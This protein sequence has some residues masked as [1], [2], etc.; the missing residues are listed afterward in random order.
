MGR[1]KT[2]MPWVA[3]LLILCMVVTLMPFWPSQ[4]V[5]A[6][7]DCNGNDHEVRFGAGTRI[8]NLSCSADNA[9]Q[10]FYN[11]MTPGFV[12]TETDKD[13]R[14]DW[15]N[16][17][18]NTGVDDNEASVQFDIRIANN[19]DLAKLAQSGHAKVRLGWN[20]LVSYAGHILGIETWTRITSM[21]V[22]VDGVKV[23]SDRADHGDDTGSRAATVDIGPNSVI[24]IELYGEGDDDDGDLTG[25]RGFYIKFEDKERPVLD[26]YTFIGNG[27]E[28]FNTT[29]QQNELY[30]K[31]S[32]YL[33]LT[34]NFSEPV[35]PTAV[36]PQNSDN[37]LKQPIFINPDGTGLPAAGEQQY[38]LN[39]TYTAGNLDT[40]HNG[41]TFQ[42]TGSKYHSSG[43]LPLDPKKIDGQSPSGTDD[44]NKSILEKM[45]GA[46]FTD[47]AGNIATITS[48]NFITPNNASNNYL[49]GKTVNPFDY[50]NGGYR[51]IVDAV[52]PK[53]TKVGNGI[54]PEILTGVTLNKNDGFDFTVQ[55]TEPAIVKRGWA[56]ADTYLLLN[57][58]MKAKYVSGSGTSTW[59]FHLDIQGTL[60]EEAPLLKVIA[61]THEMANGADSN[62]LQDYAGNMLVQP[63]NYDSN[64]DGLFVPPD[65]RLLDPKFWE[66]SN[67]NSKIDWAQLSIDNTPPTFSYRYEF[68]SATNAV[69]MKN[70]KITIDA[71]DAPLYVPSKDPVGAGTTRPSKGIYR[72][73]NMTGASSPAVGLVY[74]MWSQDKTD[75]FVKRGLDPIPAVKRYSLSAKQPREDLYPEL[76]AKYDFKIANNKTNLIALPPEALTDENSGEWY[77]HTWTA[78]MTWDTAR[79]LMQ[80]EKKKNYVLNNPAQ[81]QAWKDEASGSDADKTFYADSKALAEVGKYGDLNTWPLADFQKDDSNWTHDVGT[82]KIDNRAPKVTIG[83]ALNDNSATVQ[84]PLTIVDE[85]SG[86]KTSQYQWVKETGGVGDPSDAGWI[87]ATLTG[88]SAT[89]STLN[90]VV[91]DGTYRLYVKTSDNAGNER[92]E[93]HTKLITV[94]STNTISGSFEP[95]ANP[96][97][98]KSH[99]ITFKISGLPAAPALR[100]VTT[101][102]YSTHGVVQSVMPLMTV[103]S[104][105][106][107]GY[108]FSDSLVRPDA[109]SFVGLGTYDDNNGVRT[110]TVPADPTKNGEQYIHIMVKVS[111]SGIDKFYYYSKLYYFDNLPPDVKF[112]KSGSEY[113]LESVN[114]TVTVDEKY[115]KAGVTQRYMLLDDTKPAPDENTAGWTELPA[116][117]AVSIDNKALSLNPGDTASYRV[118]VLVKDCAGNSAVIKSGAFKIMKPEASDKPPVDVK[119]DLLYLYGDAEDGYTAI[120]KLGLVADAGDKGA[121]DFSVSPDNGASWVKWRPYTNFVAL[122][123]PT[124]NAADLHIQVKYRTPSGVVGEPRNLDIANVAKNEPVYALATLNNPKPVN[125]STGAEIEITAPLGLKVVPSAVNPSEPTRSGN[126]FTVR[127]N[128]LYAF[129]LT[130]PAD[131]TRKDTLYIVIKNVDGTPPEGTIEYLT[132]GAT[133]GNVTVKLTDLSE[134][135][136]VINNNGRLTHTFEENGQFIFNIMDEAGNA[137]TVTANVY[138]IDKTPPNVKVVRSYAYGENN[139]Q[140]YGTIR[141]G[142]GNVIFSAGVSLVLQ[143]VNPTDKDFIVLDG[144]KTITLEQNGIASFMV[145]DEF[146]NTTVIKETVDNIINTPPA[147]SNITYTFVDENGDPLPAEQIVTI[148]GQQYAKGKVKVT[149]I[150]KTTA[151]NKVFSGTTPVMDSNTGLYT[152]QISAQDGTFTYSRTFSGEGS[153]LV[154]L[155]DV[156]GNLKKVPVTIKGLD[157]TAPTLQLKL[158]TV[159]IAQNKPNFNFRTDLGGYTATDNVSKADQIAVSISGL[160]LSKLGRQRIAYTAKDQ[161]GNTTLVYQDVIVVSD[162]GMLIF[163]NDV[164]ISGSS[165]ESALFDTNTLTFNIT[166]YNVM[167]VNGQDAINEAGTYDVLYQPGLYR[168]GQMKYI[169]SKITYNELVNGQFKVTFPEVGW[170]TII[171]RTQERERVYSTFFVG[172]KQ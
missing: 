60:N 157:N 118:F 32:E 111:D 58:G 98:V 149:F 65:D 143:K 92:L 109:A 33:K 54:Q 36:F 114:L 163:A 127:T 70:G 125:P 12:Q 45:R 102:T 49:D 1:H 146:G 159:G 18:I 124:N 108:A 115:S 106:Y 3:K 134:P 10:N 116:G 21:S 8:G 121:Y 104:S 80:Y 131:V 95:E 166:K 150:G 64:T 110:Y 158:A 42:Y 136:T 144:K 57:N 24:H 170:Y 15:A 152:N 122:K 162:A 44:M 93:K 47:F 139:S 154:A 50:N 87:N 43:N 79:E 123:V 27:A 16:G 90:Q 105:V 13:A 26:D 61:L 91:E 59:T 161:V 52:P 75:P 119:S 153:T 78:D 68:G 55:M 137:G 140:T 99:P 165:G 85:H 128:G 164:L 56:V 97:Y 96:S 40:L 148:D 53:Y 37:F 74:Y 160:D 145:E 89:L 69:Y 71:D 147:P 107:A 129:D 31:K 67:V 19:P 41:I 94:N 171:V 101:V 88:G 4:T 142:S 29:I 46:V 34:Y 30:A 141:D 130:D 25:V 38:M 167:N 113:P 120:V 20:K 6:A 84:V 169:A 77:L 23:L 76:D 5:Q 172:G 63:A 155:S 117:G 138:T 135:V 100:S 168:E 62:V 28:N 11:N 66:S 51:V 151:P 7:S 39:T 132:T 17:D 72:P 126:K 35:M 86:V 156:L 14:Y 112:S 9:F 73:S 22:Y 103:T 48:T 83:E 133:N 2:A 81:Y 82:I